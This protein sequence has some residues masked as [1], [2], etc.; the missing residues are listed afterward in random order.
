MR[1]VNHST[2]HL[3]L[4][5]DRLRA[6]LQME[7][8][9]YASGRLSRLDRL[10]I[11]GARAIWM[12]QTS[13]IQNMLARYAPCP[14][15]RANAA[16]HLAQ[17]TARGL[18]TRTSRERARIIALTLILNPWA[19]RRLNDFFDMSRE[20]WRASDHRMLVRALRRYLHSVDVES[21]QAWERA[22]DTIKEPS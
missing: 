17:H 4:L 5:R 12:L 13:Q 19:A 22:V 2:E 3:D 14:T 18:P 8:P 6:C 21:L 1:A 9:G 7:T 20:E 16:R 10:Q 11:H 15:R